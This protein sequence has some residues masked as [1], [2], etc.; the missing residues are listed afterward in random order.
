MADAR[1]CQVPVFRYALER[2]PA[3]TYTVR[4]FYHGTMPE[5]QVVAALQKAAD[6]SAANFTFTTTD[7]PD[8]GKHEL[9]WLSV[10][11]PRCEDSA[12]P[13][14]SGPFAADT[15]RL[16]LDS[17]ARREL[18][19]RLAGGDA[20]VW[21]VIDGDAATANLLDS[22]LRK[23]EKEISVPEP[24]PNDPR[25]ADNSDLKIAFS[26]VPVSRAD[27]AEKI[28]LSMLLN[29][30]PYV[31]ETKAPTVFAVFGRGRL[32]NAFDVQNLNAN[33]IAA[34]CEFICGSC[35]CEI[36]SANP[37]IDLLLAANWDDALTDQA[38]KDP[39]LPPLVSLASIAAPAHPLPSSTP[40]HAAH[41]A[42]VDAALWRNLF[43]A[44]GVLVVAIIIGTLM[45]RR[46]P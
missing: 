28:F 5:P 35:S 27:P 23:L 10:Q 41:S 40:Q 34:T 25:T 9:P 7:A 18:V 22:Q 6:D 31:T 36:K 29:A 38:V 16:L 39:P 26:V 19:R 42:A 14:W 11:F 44:L 30:A 2:W 3:D 8:P 17:P 24:D 15:G 45:T 4:L 21:V 37:G 1:A 20:V 46:K 33:T 32:L 13:A 12:E 43:L